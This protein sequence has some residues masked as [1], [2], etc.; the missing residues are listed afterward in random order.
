M[1]AMLVAA[2]SVALASAA[3]AD[4]IEETKCGAD[5][6]CYKKS[7]W[8]GGPQIELFINLDNLQLDFMCMGFG[9]PPPGARAWI[10]KLFD[11]Y[12]GTPLNAPL[13]FARGHFDG[14]LD[15][16]SVPA[17]APSPHTILSADSKQE[18]TAAKAIIW[19]ATLPLPQNLML[20]TTQGFSLFDPQAFR[21]HL[22]QVLRD[23]N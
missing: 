12:D 22:A 5:L 18:Q 19:L 7:T 3:V 13:R 15:F 2:L 20:I 23:C 4:G 17:D 14:T 9:K 1:R 16:L 11:A 10:I 21:G 8:S 6:W